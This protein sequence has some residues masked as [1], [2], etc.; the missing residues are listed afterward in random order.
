MDR[1]DALR[2]LLDVA[3]AGSFSGVARQRAM[4]TSTVALAVSQLEQE[5]GRQ[6]VIRSTR[7]LVFTHE[8]EILLADARRIV[9]AWDAA[10]DALRE[11][12]RLRGPLRVTATNDFGRAR[13]RPLLDAFQNLH[14]DLHVTLILSDSTLDLIDHH[15]DL[16]VRSGPLPDSALRARLLV[17]GRRLVCA[18]PAY[19]NQAGRPTHPN[20]LQQHNCIILAR[21]DAPLSPWPFVDAGTSLNVK[22][23]GDRQATDG[24]VLREWAVEGRG[25]VL[26]NEWDIRDDVAAGRLETVLDDYAN[27][28]LDL[29]ALYPSGATSRRLSALIDFFADA[30]QATPVG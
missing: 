17:R 23:A 7:K 9:S 15:I 12:G 14:P 5:F 28:P 27:P 11:D 3:D 24:D 18:A 29:Y 13:V 16:A 6:I 30:L 21:P 10:A 8:G 20:D 2:L 26:K 4:A 19:W 22:V 1:I 25:V